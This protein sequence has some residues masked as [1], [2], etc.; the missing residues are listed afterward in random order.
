[1]PGGICTPDLLVR[2][3][4]RSVHARLPASNMPAITGVLASTTP[5]PRSTVVYGDWG[6]DWGGTGLTIRRTGLRHLSRRTLRSGW[7]YQSLRLVP[8]PK[9]H[10][11]PSNSGPRPEIAR[12]GRRIRTSW[13]LVVLVPGEIEMETDV[14]RAEDGVDLENVSWP[15]HRSAR[16]A[17]SEGAL[18][19]LA[20]DQ[21]GSSRS[22]E[23][24]R[25][26]DL[27][28]TD[29]EGTG[30]AGGGVAGAPR[31]AGVRARRRR[32]R[33]AGMRARLHDPHWHADPPA[34]PAAVL[35]PGAGRCRARTARLPH[36]A[37][38]RG[39]SLDCGGRADEGRAGSA[40]AYAAEHHRR[41]PTGI[42]TRKP[43]RRR[44][45][46]WNAPSANGTNWAVFG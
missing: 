22:I 15:S 5:P 6:T 11:A 34:Q 29:R 30:A 45:P 25:E 17:S 33:L 10:C 44:Q 36:D 8:F 18:V 37:A 21:S 35:A 7:L 39:Q 14:E 24:D 42:S 32:I 46:R 4:T 41:I 13:Y 12:G 43:S 3:W 9:L 1:M 19:W 2:K 38:H 28:S 16:R 27:D 31:P 20:V 26:L 40:G 23:P